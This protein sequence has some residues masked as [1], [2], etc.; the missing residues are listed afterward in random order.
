[1]EAFSIDR[2]NRLL[3]SF[4][5]QQLLNL[6]LSDIGWL[7]LANGLLFENY[8]SSIFGAANYFDEIGT[9]LL[10]FC[11]LASCVSKS[12]NLNH[13]L[14]SW[15]YLSI[16]LIVGYITI[17]L[18]SN[19]LSNIQTS[20]MPIAIDVFSCIKYPLALLSGYYV[21]PNS[22]DLYRLLLRE[23]KFLLALMLPF[24]LINQF[25]DIGMRFDFRY[26]LYSFHFI[27][28]HPASFAVIIVG[29][30]VLLLADRN[31]NTLWVFLSW[32]YLV[33]SLRSTA[34]AFAAFSFLVWLAT[35][36]NK[37][38][39]FWQIAAFTLVALYFGWSQ[40]QYYFFETDGSARRK[41][42]DVGIKVAIRYFPFGSGFATF[43]TNITAQPEYYSTLYMQYGFSNVYGLSIDNPSYLSDSFWP[44]VFGQFG[45]LGAIL[46]GASL[47]LL[48]LGCR[49]RLRT[50]NASIVPF[51]LSFSYMLIA[52]FSSSAFF[53]PMGVFLGLITAVTVCH[54]IQNGPEESLRK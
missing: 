26:G 43:G 42:F 25:I 27:F 46:F 48:F 10:I 29:F 22:K 19:R 14:T 47:L 4:R 9:V 3:S 17:G 44:I 23:A 39:H 16:A 49:N 31:R 2:N 1:M 41:L 36:K 35:R 15:E 54:Q 6:R 30:L 20:A 13:V 7:V 52:S 11:A 21:F 33:L 5:S 34:I 24:A 50:F 37:R 12:R 38:I 28:G 51:A 53:H 32:I 40:I 8:L 18:V 45:W